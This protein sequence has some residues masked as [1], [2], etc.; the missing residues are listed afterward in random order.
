MQIQVQG[1]SSGTNPNQEGERERESK[2]K[3]IL[4]MGWSRSSYSG[5]ASS[6]F[7]FC[8]SRAGICPLSSWALPEL[9]HR[10]SR[11]CWR[12]IMWTF[13]TGTW[14]CRNCSP[15]HQFEDTEWEVAM[16]EKVDTGG[17]DVR[18]KPRRKRLVTATALAI[19]AAAIAMRILSFPLPLN[20]SIYLISNLKLGTSILRQGFVLGAEKLS[21]LSVG[22]MP[23][24]SSLIEKSWGVL[25]LD[26]LRCPWDSGPH[27]L[28]FAAVLVEGQFEGFEV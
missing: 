19:A 5:N 26:A 15:R 23:S 9:M 20:L 10:H 2:P 17:E 16:G 18:R 13:N 27:G 4:G 24:S 22:Q 7:C 21:P 1:A 3:E 12:L 6:S 8:T 11:C 14:R 28:W 25:Y